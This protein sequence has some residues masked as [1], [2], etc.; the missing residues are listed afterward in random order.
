[1]IG[2]YLQGEGDPAEAAQVLQYGLDYLHMMLLGLVP[3]A[4]TNAYASTLRETG[5]TTVPMTA[6]VV[7]VLVNL[8]LNYVLI[9]G[10][11]G[12]PEMGVRGAALAT[13][14]SRYVELA[15]VA[16]IS[17]GRFLSEKRA[18]SVKF[19]TKSASKILYFA[20]LRIFF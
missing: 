8:V 6:G 5:E 3:F 2:L 10:H 7:A 15:I 9:F 20:T 11:F 17:Y 19:F 1:M 18:F 13:A 16:T 4:L 12:A 14:I